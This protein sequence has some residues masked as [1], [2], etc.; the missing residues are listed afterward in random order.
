MILVCS[1]AFSASASVALVYLYAMERTRIVFVTG[2]L[3]AVLSIL[4]GLFL[5]PPY[6][7]N[8][9]AIGRG[10]IQVT[11]VAVAVWYIDRKL[12]CETPYASLARLLAAALIC[13]ASA[14]IVLH[15]VPGIAGLAAAILAGIAVYVLAVRLLAALPQSDIDWLVRASTTLLPDS[16]HRFSDAALRLLRPSR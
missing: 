4:V 1:A 3:G 16:L 2:A 10:I 9:A 5:V 15:V 13:A 11:I 12:A 6:G 8:A 14:I 7:L